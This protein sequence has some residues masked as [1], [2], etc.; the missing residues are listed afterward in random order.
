MTTEKELP[1]YA[2]LKIPRSRF[3]FP[4]IDEID[5]KEGILFSSQ[6]IRRIK[7]SQAFSLIRFG[8]LWLFLSSTLSIIFFSTLSRYTSALFIVSLIILI[9]AIVLGI[10]ITAIG[11]W[12]LIERK[13]WYIGTPNNLYIIRKKTEKKFNWQKFTNDVKTSQEDKKITLT[14]LP[15][16]RLKTGSDKPPRKPLHLILQN[17]EN[18]E[19]TGKQIQ[20]LIQNKEKNPSISSSK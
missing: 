8:I 18:P 14:L 12:L 3:T 7:R 19:E 6:S 10:L 1:S 16:P 20:S 13:T 15:E 9:F 11:I 4:R 5:K 17:I 2:K